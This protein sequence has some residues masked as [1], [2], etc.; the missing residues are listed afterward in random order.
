MIEFVIQDHIPY[1]FISL[2]VSLLVRSFIYD[3]I[4]VFFV[5]FQ[6]EEIMMLYCIFWA[7]LET[8]KYFHYMVRIQVGV[9]RLFHLLTLSCLYIQGTCLPSH[10]IF[11]TLLDLRSTFIIL[12][13]AQL[14]GCIIW[15][16]DCQIVKYGAVYTDRLRIL[17]FASL[18]PRANAKAACKISYVGE[19]GYSWVW[20]FVSRDGQLIGSNI[21]GRVVGV[22]LMVNGV[23]KTSGSIEQELKSCTKKRVHW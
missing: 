9:R 1:S 3:M 22:F 13:P 12:I 14:F 18:S 8:T 20:R 10:V 11:L 16:Q 21:N 7:N 2:F 15:V 6:V 4:Q 5:S 17:F 23:Q 19:L